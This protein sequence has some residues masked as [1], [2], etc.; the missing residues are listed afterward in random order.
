[1]KKIILTIALAIFTFSLWAAQLNPFAYGLKST[2]DAKTVTLSGEFYINAPATSVTTY[3]VDAGGRRYQLHAYG[4]VSAKGKITFSYDL[5]KLRIP[6]NIP[7]TWCVEVVGQNPTSPTFVD[8]SNRLYA[9]YS[10]DIDNNPQNANFGTVF[11]VEGRP[12]AEGNS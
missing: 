3:A 2:Y 7:L 8:N 9:P 4:K 10:V 1:M 6:T 11:C 12:D 5:L